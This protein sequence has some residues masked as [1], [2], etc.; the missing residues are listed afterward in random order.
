V[1][2]HLLNYHEKR[3]DRGKRAR[4]DTIE[5]QDMNEGQ[6][7]RSR[8]PFVL[9][10]VPI[11]TRNA[12]HDTKVQ[13]PGRAKNAL[14]KFIPP[15]L[16]SAIHNLAFSSL[17]NTAYVHMLVLENNTGSA[18]KKNNMTVR[19]SKS[20][21]MTAASSSIDAAR[22]DGTQYV[23]AHMCK[24]PNAKKLS[25]V[26]KKRMAALIGW[27]KRR[28]QG[29]IGGPA[30]KMK[31][32]T[33]QSVITA[34][35]MHSSERRTSAVS[36]TDTEGS[37]SS[38]EEDVDSGDAESEAEIE[39][40]A[41]KPLS[42]AEAARLGWA[43]RKKMLAAKAAE[44]STSSSDEEVEEEEFEKEETPK[45]PLSRAE[46][47]R[48]GWERRKKM[49][50]E[51][52]ILAGKE[53]E[54]PTPL[55]RREAAKM[56]W[57]RRKNMLAETKAEGQPIVAKSNKKPSRVKGYGAAARARAAK[58]GW[59][60]R[61]LILAGVDP[62]S[63]P[64]EEDD[65][66]QPENV[67]T[68][69]DRAKAGWENRKNMLAARSDSSTVDSTSTDES[70]KPSTKGTKKGPAWL[71]SKPREG[72]KRSRR[73]AEDSADSHEE[74]VRK[75]NELVSFLKVTR[76]WMEFHPSSRHG[77][78]TA[79]YGY[80]PASIAS[81]IRGGTISK[82]VV[83]EHGTLGVHYALDYEGY[84]GLKEMIDSFGMDYSPY[85]TEEMHEVSREILGNRNAMQVSA[86]DLGEDL[87]WQE[88]QQAEEKR[89]EEYRNKMNLKN[90][91]DESSGGADD[92]L[93]VANILASLN[94]GATDDDE[95]QDYKDQGLNHDLVDNQCPDVSPSTNTDV[96]FVEDDDSDK[97]KL[98]DD[99]VLFIQSQ[100]D[101][102]QWSF[103]ICHG[104]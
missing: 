100:S 40:T 47:A 2:V 49:L 62:A 15:F 25:K 68:A 95:E 84:G 73:L 63:I 3:E 93:F 42:R 13:R 20:E 64:Q 104:K 19:S 45:K 11:I 27:E 55:G 69:E 35:S 65:E 9:S 21:E 48:L 97:R 79:T 33:S 78:G 61:K 10:S 67:Y 83:L 88:L 57:E 7:S 6:G 51:A 53:E 8:C 31:L 103:G 54:K 81:F 77:S 36:K 56:G 91:K 26:E 24:R 39:E 30:K 32:A 94:H 71:K 90:E 101:F 43:R 75:M 96:T 59:E 52:K 102:S 72:A 17:H 12:Q 5:A 28:N 82:S 16:Q 87:P 70:S 44:T 14:K 46:A 80:I 4:V 37:T 23:Q 86:W 18:V 29:Q 50:A 74:S 66:P 89:I 98:V 58:R 60:R 1:G 99:D 76:G 41:K 85:P 22:K 34:A 38:S 92:L